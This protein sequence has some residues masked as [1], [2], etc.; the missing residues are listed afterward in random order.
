MKSSGI[1]PIS[2]RQLVASTGIVMVLYILSDVLGLARSVA[3]TYQFGTSAEMDAYYAAFRVPDFIFNLLA[4]G[5]LASAFIPPFTTLLAAG[6]TRG[7]WRLATQVINLVLA[8]TTAVCVVAF[9]FAEPFVAYLVAPGFAPAEQQLTAQL[10]R[11]MLLTPIIFSVSGI[12]MGIL[13]AHQHFVLPAAAPSMYNIGI[14]FGALVLAPRWGVYGLALG[15]VVGALLHLLIQVPWLLRQKIPFTRSLGIRD[16]QVRHVVNLMIPRAVGNAAV[17]LNF[18]VNVFLASSLAV[19]SLAALNYAFLIM[20]LPQAVIAQAI[21]TVLFPTFARMV[22]DGKMDDLRRAFSTVFRGVLF[23]S[24]PASVGLLLLR[25]PVI[26]VLFQRGDFTADSTAQTAFALQFFAIGLFAQSGLEIL[27]RAFYALHDTATPVR[28]SIASVVLNIILSLILIQPLAH[29]GLALANS[30]ATILE[31]L[32]LLFLLRPR[33]GGVD[34]RNLAASTLKMLVGAAAMTVAIGWFQMTALAQVPLF[35]LLGGIV[36]GG[37]AYL[38]TMLV[39]QSDEIALA[40]RLVRRGR[41]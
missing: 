35:A 32:V 27:A 39:L 16:A 19:G 12:V 7:A 13:N 24:I 37:G 30:I 29:G 26:Q 41:E 23:L 4:G 15:V 5:A 36:F 6:D 18:W 40:L 21:G 2:A 9:L 17:Q 14:I 8:V 25:T 3:I 33:L 38:L 1:A 31:M 11:V 20:L 34:E 28:I 22:A 10:M